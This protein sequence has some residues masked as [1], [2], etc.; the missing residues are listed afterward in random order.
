MVS[1][2]VLIPIISENPVTEAVIVPSVTAARASVEICPR[3]TTGAM[4][5]EYSRI[6]A[7]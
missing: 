4:D 5:R 1:I 7:L 3:E 6:C 2:A